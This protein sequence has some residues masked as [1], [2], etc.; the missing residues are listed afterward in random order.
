M[1]DVRTSGR[2]R[3]FVNVDGDR[4]VNEGAKRDTLCK[5]IFEQPGATYWIVVNKVRYPNLT[6]FDKDGQR[7]GDMIALGNVIAADTIEKLAAATGMDAK[8]LQASIDTYNAVVAGEL[9]DP[10]GFQATNSNDVQLVEGPWY[11]CKKVPTVHH[12]MGGVRVNINSQAMTADGEPIAG[13]FA[14]GEVTGGIHGNNRL[15][16]NAICDCMTFG[17]NAGLRAAQNAGFGLEK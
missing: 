7:M 4:F 8:K 11:A 2:N 12:T 17:R 1:K 9:E 13:L 15:G 6:D 5:A 3:V 10:L 14:A 16:G